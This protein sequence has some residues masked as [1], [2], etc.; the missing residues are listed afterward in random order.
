AVSVK[1]AASPEEQFGVVWFTAKTDVDRADSLVTLNDI[2]ITKGSFP[3]SPD[4]TDQ[5]VKALQASGPQQMADVSFAHLK[6]QIALAQAESAPQKPVE[7]KNDVPKI[8][9]NAG[10]AVRVQVDGQPVLRQVPGFELFRVINT[11]AVLLF[12]QAQGTYYLHV[13]G[14]WAAAQ[15]L[16]GPWAES[17]THP[18][19]LDP[20]LR[21]VTK[22]GQVNALDDPGEYV[23]R[24]A[25]DGVFPTIYV[26]T[27]P[28][29]LIMTRGAPS[30]EPISGTSL[31]DV[32]NTDDNVI[33]DPTNSLQ[34]V[35][36]SGRWFETNS[37]ETGPWSYVPNDKLPADFAK[38][39]VTHPRGVVLPSVAG[40]PPAREAVID[41][42]I[43]ETAEVT[44][45]TTRLTTT[46]GGSPQLQGIEGTPLQYVANSQYPVIRVDGT[47][48]YAL[49][50]AVWFEGTSVNGPW[51]VADSVPDVIST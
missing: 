38:I 6:A 42:S 1:D 24:S 25:A 43:P 13:V 22:G 48:W 28:A 16:D 33:V 11:Y 37:L 4:K 3:A 26:S 10:P 41:N 34:Y 40:T 39:P 19:S 18:A 9:F 44:R 47:T 31:L 29:E 32:S 21:T 20:I 12:D 30:Y 35:L 14:R 5:Y 46:Y 51:A 36:I 2:T 15:S 8:Y 7:V 50:D 45:A 17:S 23:T 27:V 49:E